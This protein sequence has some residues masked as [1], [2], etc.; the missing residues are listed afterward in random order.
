MWGRGRGE[1]EGRRA[2]RIFCGGD[3]MLGGVGDG[4]GD[5]ESPRVD[6]E[7]MWTGWGGG[8]AV[9]VAPAGDRA[10]GGIESA[11]RG[12]GGDDDGER[13]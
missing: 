8:D 5:G 12:C 4:D 7:R 11:G 1:E 3:F 10:R 2:R 13:G 6:V 9:E